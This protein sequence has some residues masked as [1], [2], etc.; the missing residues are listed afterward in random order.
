MGAIALS[1]LAPRSSQEITHMIRLTFVGDIACDRP[2]LKA[3]RKWGKYDFSRVFQ[4]SGVFEN[5]DLVI[6]NLETCFGG[7][8]YGTKAYHYSSPDSFCDAIR[9]AGFDIVSTANN[10]C[11]D[12]GV[13]GLIRTLGILDNPST[14][15]S[16]QWLF[17]VLTISK[18]ASRIA[19]QKLSGEL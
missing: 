14:P 8:H 18:P 4:T 9:D 6:G 13:D 12:E 10:H 1:K 11:L 3:A 19:S 7:G 17:A 5:S 16:R 2:L 15:S